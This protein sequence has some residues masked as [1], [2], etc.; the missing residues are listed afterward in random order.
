MRRKRTEEEEEEEEENQQQ[1]QQGAC[2]GEMSDAGV[3][4]ED[5]GGMLAA[6][7]TVC[8]HGGGGS[9]SA[10]C[11]ALVQGLEPAWVGGVLHRRGASEHAARGSESSGVR[12]VRDVRGDLRW[13]WR[14]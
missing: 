13:T 9:G 10:R 5:V 3:G 11:L 2:D 8:A 4:H 6:R 1:K 12:Q 14:P 7:A